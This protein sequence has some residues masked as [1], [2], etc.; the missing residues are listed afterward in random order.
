MNINLI[1]VYA[2]PIDE[3]VISDSHTTAAAA[4][5]ESSI[6]LKGATIIV[7]DDKK[8][9][10]DIIRGGSLLIINDHI[11]DVGKKLSTPIPEGTEHHDPWIH[12]YSQALLRAPL[13]T[14]GLNVL[15]D[16]YF[17]KFLDIFKITT[18]I[19][20]DDSYISILMSL[21][22]SL[23]AGITSVLDHTHGTFT[24][25]H[26]DAMLKAHIDSGAR[27][28]NCYSVAQIASTRGGKFSLDYNGGELG[29]WKCS[30]LEQLAEEASWAD[31][32]VQ[33]GLAWDSE[34]DET[35]IKYGFDKAA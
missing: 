30:Q 23:D 21:A 19:N 35:E 14:L 16:E 24:P 33:L 17:Y 20:A 34:R 15:F 9:K 5:K 18:R 31:G 32:R 22:D 11:A 3:P 1:S 29:G 12:R 13:Q 25:K 2:Q 26:I 4:K 6:L 27:V 8:N 7:Y 28:W 10:L